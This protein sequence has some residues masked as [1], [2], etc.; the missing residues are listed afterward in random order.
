MKKERYRQQRLFPTYN[1]ACCTL[2]LQYFA[3]HSTL[4]MHCNDD[5]DFFFLLSLVLLL[6]LYTLYLSYICSAACDG[7]LLMPLQLFALGTYYLCCAMQRCVVYD[8]INAFC[9]AKLQYIQTHTQHHHH[10]TWFLFVKNAKRPMH[11]E[12]LVL[13]RKKTVD[14]CK[15]T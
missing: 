10:G 5:D 13:D 1:T 8:T 2:L 14:R 11:I 9:N 3:A 12:S 6:L 7:W 4:S 15:Y